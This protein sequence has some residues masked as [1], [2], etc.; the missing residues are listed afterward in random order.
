MVIA[1]LATVFFG[2]GTA[3]I[4]HLQRRWWHLDATQFATAT[5][6]A[7]QSTTTRR[8]CICAP[9]GA[10][11]GTAFTIL[12]ALL[13][14]NEAVG[15]SRWLIVATACFWAIAAVLALSAYWLGVPRV[16]VLPAFRSNDAFKAATR[17]R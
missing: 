3:L 15:I 16:L 14:L 6:K 1:I 4:V 12:G 8:Q 5:G 13:I 11:L 2:A 7:W 10:L 17:R 9:G